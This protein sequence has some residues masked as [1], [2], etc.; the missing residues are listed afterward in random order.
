MISLREDQKVL[1]LG[2]YEQG[3]TTLAKSL[4]GL[5]RR[6]LV[7]DPRQDIFRTGL[8]DF[9]AVKKQF[10]KTG[11]V[12]YHPGRGDILQ[13]FDAFCEYAM[14]QH[15]AMVF[16][17]EPASLGPPSSYPQSFHDLHRIGH[18]RGLGV[19]VATHSVWDLPHV[20]HQANHL[21]VF[22][23]VRPVDLNV[24]TQ[25]LSAQGVE[26]V[27]RAPRYWFWHRSAQHDGPVQPLPRQGLPPVAP[28]PPQPPS[29]PS[30]PAV[31]GSSIATPSNAALE[32]ISRG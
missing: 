2:D 31:V 28:Q 24:L 20:M 30:P 1:I 29:T 3:K 11:Q 12:V 32:R 21:F 18:A 22:R 13:K 5:C 4:V 8:R 14:T 9:G 6:Y 23:V 25:M 7:W 26:W 27:K 15:S 19:M 17:D 16:I 10:E